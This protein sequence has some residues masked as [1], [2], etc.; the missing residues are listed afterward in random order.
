MKY[1]VNRHEEAKKQIGH[2]MNE[3]G[4]KLVR[5]TEHLEVAGTDAG[6]GKKN[7]VNMV[8]KQSKHAKMHFEHLDRYSESLI[9]DVRDYKFQPT[10]PFR[11]YR[12]QCIHLYDKYY[13]VKQQVETA[14]GP[15]L[16][17]LA[18]DFR[19]LADEAREL[20][21]ELP[22]I[23]AAMLAEIDRQNAAAA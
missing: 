1:D 13:A 14:A 21:K 17:H 2:S 16:Q 6:S 10:G 4:K 19:R 23:K 15:D 22:S 8:K 9:S 5:I 12:E 3:T 7:T 18:D 20:R 11:E